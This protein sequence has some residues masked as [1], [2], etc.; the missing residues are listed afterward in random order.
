MREALDLGD[1]VLEAETEDV[2]DIFR[3]GAE[4]PGLTLVEPLMPKKLAAFE[5]VDSLLNLL[6]TRKIFLNLHE[7]FH[8]PRDQV[9]ERGVH[10]ALAVDNLVWSESELPEMQAELLDEFLGKIETEHLV[11]VQDPPVVVFI[12]LFPDVIRK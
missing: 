9:V 11:L 2:G 12:D 8:F 5:S 6:L 1:K 7:K 3:L 4:F 10:F